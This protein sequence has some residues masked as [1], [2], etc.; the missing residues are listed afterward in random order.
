MLFELLVQNPLEQGF[1]Q[2]GS[3]VFWSQQAQN[4][5]RSAGFLHHV[6]R[7]FLYHRPRCNVGQHLQHQ[8]KTAGWTKRVE[9]SRDGRTWAVC[10]RVSRHSLV[11]QE[12]RV[13]ALPRNLLGR[14]PVGDEEAVLPVEPG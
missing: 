8:E 6:D 12:G 2:G 9:L 3:N 1:L 7:Y 14:K 11:E 5:P 13:L 10:Q 4:L